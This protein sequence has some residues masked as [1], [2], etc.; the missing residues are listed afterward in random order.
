MGVKNPGY[1]QGQMTIEL[2]LVFPVVIVVAVVAVNAVLFFSEC[3]A[4]DNEFREMVRIH[5]S[6]PAYG[7]G[8]EQSKAQVETSL[9][10]LFDHTFEKSRVSLEATKGN[11]LRF[12]AVFSFWPTLFGLGLKTSVFGLSMPPLNHK[13]AMVVDCYKPGILI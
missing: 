8:I 7:Q 11:H 5:A 2:A 13:V 9:Q 3:A 4:F 12:S 1:E 10:K 6:S